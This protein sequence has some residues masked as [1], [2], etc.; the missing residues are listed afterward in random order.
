M[1][2]LLG[3]F[4]SARG[5]PQTVIGLMVLILSGCGQSRI[6]FPQST[7]ETCGNEPLGVVLKRG[8]KLHLAGSFSRAREE[9]ARCPERLPFALFALSVDDERSRIYLEQ[10]REKLMLEVAPPVID[11]HVEAVAI[12]NSLLKHPEGN[13]ELFKRWK[14]AE[15]R[16]LAE[17]HSMVWAELVDVGLYDDALRFEE[18]ILDELRLDARW[19]REM[20]ECN[21]K[22]KVAEGRSRYVRA[23]AGGGRVAAARAEVEG[24][25]VDDTLPY[26][27]LYSERLEGLGVE[28]LVR[29]IEIISTP[30]DESCNLPPNG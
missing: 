5:I 25:F 3:R 24:Q 9:F 20:P 7:D 19:A 13:A 2:K 1:V 8:K 27:K 11:Q 12:W 18:Q 14:L 30:M 10:L 22:R 28:D 16:N 4:F 26:G 29:D 21:H 15:S 23:L 17:L 6:Q